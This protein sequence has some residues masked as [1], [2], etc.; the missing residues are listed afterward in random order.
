MTEL[1]V[2]RTGTRRYTGQSSRGAQVLIGSEDVEGVFTPGEL[3]KIA[4]AACTGM[5]SDRPLSRRLGDDYDATVRVS[6]DAD[7]ENEQYPQLDEV[8][9]VD[10]SELDPEAAE[11]LLVVVERAIDKVCTVGRTLKAGTQVSLTMETE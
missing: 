8:L 3:M 5:S 6:G 11:R 10:L 7:R 2:Q 4:L 9:E 1:W